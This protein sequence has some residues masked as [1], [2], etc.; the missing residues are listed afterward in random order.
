MGA[1]SGEKSSGTDLWAATRHASAS[2]QSSF[3]R[4]F[5]SK[6]KKLKSTVLSRVIKKINLRS[7][8]SLNICKRF[9]IG[10]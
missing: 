4:D 6:R 8:L 2:Q 3:C 9:E 10:E 1:C 7:M 5:V